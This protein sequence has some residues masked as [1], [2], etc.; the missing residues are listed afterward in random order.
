MRPPSAP[1]GFFPRGKMVLYRAIKN[2]SAN[3][4]WNVRAFTRPFEVRILGRA[5]TSHTRVHPCVIWK[6]RAQKPRL[7]SEQTGRETTWGSY[8]NSR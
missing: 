6:P 5:S 4:Q 1:A 2:D 3:A 8:I 7:G